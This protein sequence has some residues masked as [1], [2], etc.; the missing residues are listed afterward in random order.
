MYRRELIQSGV[1][2]TAIWVDADAHST[3][4]NAIFSIRIMRAHQCQ[5]A[6]IVTSWYHT[7]RAFNC[8]R[9]YAP[10]FVFYAQPTYPSDAVAKN[11]GSP[12]PSI[13]K[14]YP[15]TVWYWLRYG[16]CPF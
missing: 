16:I 10:G 2:A 15:K 6:L 12:V 5:S 4:E 11:W 7:R 14:E 9:H 8:F 3:A 13:L 1:P